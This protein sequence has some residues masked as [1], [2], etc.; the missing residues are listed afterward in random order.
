MRL[1]QQDINQEKKETKFEFFILCY[2]Q[3]LRQMGARVQNDIQES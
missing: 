1:E 2:D 3:T